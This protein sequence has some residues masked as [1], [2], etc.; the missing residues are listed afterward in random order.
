MKLPLAL[1]F[2]LLPVLAHSAVTIDFVAGDSFNGVGAGESSDTFTDATTGFSGEILT[3]AIAPATSSEPMGGP[4][5]LSTFTNNNFGFSGLGIDSPGGSGDYGEVNSRF[6][7]GESWTFSWNVATQ[8]E[9]ISFEQYASATEE[10]TIQSELFK[11]LSD[12]NPTA[13]V[14]YDS[15]DGIFTFGINQ[16]GD[17]FSLTDLS[18]GTIIDIA[19]YTDITI[20]YEGTPGSAGSFGDFSAV[21][22]LSFSLV[23]E[24]GNALIGGLLASGLFFRR[25][26]R[27]A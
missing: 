25:R 20:T 3:N 5:V 9:G 18:G 23:P 14:S 6:D 1:T 4:A 7:D 21:S 12:I 19:A 10:F 15:T 22:S 17:S 24:P 16:S 27:R 13:N 26:Q 8:F 11:G 2:S